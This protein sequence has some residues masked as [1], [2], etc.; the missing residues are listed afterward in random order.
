[1]SEDQIIADEVRRRLAR[2]ER[3]TSP[4]EVAVSVRAGDATLRG[5]VGSFRQHRAAVEIAKST[6]GVRHVEDELRVD[7]R[8]YSSDD[9]IRGAAIQ[10]LMS[11]PEVPDDRIEVTVH[12]AW[13]TLKGEVKRQ[14]ESNAAFDAVAEV[15]G[16]GGIT[17]KI[18]VITAGIDG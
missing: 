9:E 8:G 15:P 12:A 6:P 10:A 2:D 4:A 11:N 13:L 17:N 14:D 1:M 7:L 3:I 18:A 16:V 5:S